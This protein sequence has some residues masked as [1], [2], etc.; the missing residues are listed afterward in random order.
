MSKQPFLPL[1]F[2]DFLASTAEWTGEERGLYLLL[3]G[4]TWSLGS[5]PLQP[6]LVRRVA[7][8]DA[9]LFNR[10]WKTVRT[11]FV[12]KDGRLINLRLEEHREKTI[13][14]SA[15]NSNSGRRGAAIRWAKTGSE[16]HESANG[17]NMANAIAAPCG[18]HE[19]ANGVTHSNPSHPIPSHISSLRSEGRERPR[20]KG[21]KRCPE[22]FEPD[23]DFARREVPG[24][25]AEAEAA[26][27]RDFEFAKPRSD[28][29]ATW[30][31]WIRTARDR[32]TYA[33][34]AA[35]P[36]AIQWQ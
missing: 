7:A 6:E 14:L 3:L 30:R 19:S 27:F 12:E 33:K 26:K 21:Q 32:G 22:G 10:C 23:L 8:W 34:A 9:K 28:W 5:L 15:K 16:R 35:A 25:D 29:P 24:I 1:F 36:G 11:K 2:G 13:E 4:H 18:R 17:E 20:P 31:N